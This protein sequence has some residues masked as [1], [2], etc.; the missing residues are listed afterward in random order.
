MSE[1]PKP[2]HDQDTEDDSVPLGRLAAWSVL[3]A[4]LA[5]GL[6]AYFR[7]QPRIAPLY[8]KVN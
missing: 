4:L 3:A 6:V 8:D 2:S 7:Y 5:L 1:T